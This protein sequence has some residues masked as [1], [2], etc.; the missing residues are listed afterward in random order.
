MNTAATATPSN[1]ALRPIVPYFLPLLQKPAA[2]APLGE[3]CLFQVSFFMP[4]VVSYVL[5]RNRLPLDRAGCQAG[6]EL[7]LQEQEEEDDRQDREER[8]GHQHPVLLLVEADHL[9]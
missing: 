8:P 2:K 6:D 1:A 3:R 4:F 5:Y 9:I 7:S